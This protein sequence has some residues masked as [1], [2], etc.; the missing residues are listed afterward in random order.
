MDRNIEFW[1]IEKYGGED[2]TWRIASRPITFNHA[3]RVLRRYKDD[4]LGQRS[5]FA[6]SEREEFFHNTLRLVHIQ[7]GNILPIELVI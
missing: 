2:G 1:R 4:L 3:I 6:R 5:L 7:S